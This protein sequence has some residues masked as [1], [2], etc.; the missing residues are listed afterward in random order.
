MS[1]APAGWRLQVHDQLPSTADLIRRSAEDGEAERLAILARRQTAGRGTHGRSWES[2][3]G[4]LYLSVLLRP[5][6]PAREVPQ[7][8]L[9]AAVALYDALAPLAGPD[10]TLKW[11][12]DVLIRG[13][14]CAGILAEA[15]L[16]ARGW[17]DWLSF[18]FG[19]NLAHAPQLSGRR[20][21]AL[22]QPAPEPE[23]AAAAVL[24]SLDRWR[25]VRETEGFEPIRVAWLAR[26]HR[27]GVALTVTAA[28]APL[29]GLFDGLDDSGALRLRTERG[30]ET[31]IA[32]QVDA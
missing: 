27:P 26:G 29:A 9:L 31:V 3:I 30:L 32:G 2:P 24:A 23:V 5:T 25:A 18:G 8:G 7:W 14:K 19:V 20:T 22:P 1:T 11:P 16:D 15:S 12:N 28:G 4:N 6:A 17:L 13:A 10:L 21:A